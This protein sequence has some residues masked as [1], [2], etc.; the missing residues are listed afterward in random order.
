MCVF[1]TVNTELPVT[2]PVPYFETAVHSCT[3]QEEGWSER[4]EDTAD[5][6]QRM[7]LK[8]SR[9]A[10]RAPVSRKPVNQNDRCGGTSLSEGTCCTVW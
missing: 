6:E 3:L 5:R 7:S 10:S 2:S 4:W 1:R 9:K 8:N